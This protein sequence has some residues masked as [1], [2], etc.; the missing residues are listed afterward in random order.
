MKNIQN[1]PIIIMRESNYEVLYRHICNLRSLR[2]KK[3]F[4]EEVMKQ[5]F[6]KTSE[7]SYLGFK[8]SIYIL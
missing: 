4:K 5:N 7:N 3:S 6:L 2:W 8:F 1:L